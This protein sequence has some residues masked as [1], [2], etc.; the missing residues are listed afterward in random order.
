[1]FVVPDEFPSSTDLFPLKPV[2]VM[3]PEKVAVS[4]A[5]AMTVPLRAVI[6]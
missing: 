6:T 3:S 4:V 2:A 1:M 5:C